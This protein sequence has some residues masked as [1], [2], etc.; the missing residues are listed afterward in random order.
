MKTYFGRGAYIELDKDPA[1]RTQ[2]HKKI[3]RV[4]RIAGTESGHWLQLECGHRPM[5]FGRLEHAAGL[6]YCNVCAGGE[7]RD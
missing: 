6:L 1:P 2:Y 5:A 4:D 3:V 7:R